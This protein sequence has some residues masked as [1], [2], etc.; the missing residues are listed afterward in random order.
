MVASWVEKFR[1]ELPAA[2]IGV[3]AEAELRDL[4]KR[5]LR[6]GRRFIDYYELKPLGITTTCCMSASGISLPIGVEDGGKKESVSVM[7]S[8]GSSSPIE[9]PNNRRK[10]TDV[11]KTKVQSE[12]STKE[13]LAGN[14][15]SAEPEQPLDGQPKLWCFPTRDLSSVKNARR[16]MAATGRLPS[17]LCRLSPQILSWLSCAWIG[18]T[19][20]RWSAASGRRC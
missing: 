15:K 14:F 20:L 17:T 5:A 10:N 9:I 13:H 3:P 2:G 12:I 6:S 8:V 1:S 19:S 7:S 4:V 18:L 16:R 11:L